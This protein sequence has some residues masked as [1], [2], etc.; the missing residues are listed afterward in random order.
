M[1]ENNQPEEDFSPIKVEVMCRK[2]NRN[3]CLTDSFTGE[4]RETVQLYF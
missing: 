1:N 2:C 3:Q 4:E